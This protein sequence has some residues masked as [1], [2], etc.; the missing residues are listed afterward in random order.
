M[1]K[2]LIALGILLPLAWA[3]AAAPAPQD[4]VKT[5][6]KT[7]PT[8][9]P[10]FRGPNG[11]G[12]SEDKNVP[13]DFGETKNVLWKTPLPGAGNSSPIVWGDKIFLESATADGKERLLV[14]VNASKGN[15]LWS[16]SV[17]GDKAKTH[18]KNSL[19]SSTPATDGERVY[20]SFWDGEKVVLHAFD[21]EGK[22]LWTQ[23]LGKFKSQHGY[24]GSPIIWQDKVFV[25]FDQDGAAAILAFDAKTGKP[26]WDKPRDAFRTCYSTPFLLE[27][28]NGGSEL[29]VASTAG[30]TAYEPAS[31]AENWKWKWEF[32]GMA[33]RTVGSPI[34]ANGLILTSSGDGNGA[35]NMVAL[36]PGQQPSIAWQNKRSFPYVPTMLVRGDHVYF[37]NDGGVAA[38]HLL[39]SGEEIWK[40]RLGGGFSASPVMIDGKVYAPCEDG[41]VY[42]FAAEPTYKLLAKNTLGEKENLMASPAVAGGR[43]FIRGK[44]DL[45]CIG[46]KAE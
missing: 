24:G 15:V 41:K 44:N 38:C 14:C 20:A 10:R 34:A 9:W 32:E 19:A 33:L 6:A 31:G 8:Q 29:I 39:K 2:G 13:V 4:T 1:R 7:S 11:T 42:V 3:V 16:K 46:K 37:V 5:D 25:N 28:P 36:N 23:E 21:M 40:E 43:L 17:S 26:A 45:Y 27:K 35:R 30:I 18:L 12:I 22:P